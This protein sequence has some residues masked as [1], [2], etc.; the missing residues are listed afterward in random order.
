MGWS[1]HLSSPK[2]R[3][4]VSALD[5]RAGFP[6]FSWDLCLFPDELPSRCA[7]CAVP[8]MILPKCFA[9]FLLCMCLSTDMSSPSLPTGS[10]LVIHQGLSGFSPRWMQYLVLKIQPV[11]LFLHA[12]THIRL[13]WE[14]CIVLWSPASCALQIVL[15]CFCLSGFLHCTQSIWHL[16]L[17]CWGMEIIVNIL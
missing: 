8:A 3:W 5:F 13:Y 1:D 10:C 6:D 4:V 12:A 9:Y 7:S 2:R 17:T 16:S 14:M 15:H 11:P